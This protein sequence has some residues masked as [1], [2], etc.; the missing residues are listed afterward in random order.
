VTGFPWPEER[1]SVHELPSIYM[2]ALQYP[3]FAITFQHQFFH[4]D[5]GRGLPKNQIVLKNR[6]SWRRL[7]KTKTLP[8]HDADLSVLRALHAADNG[9]DKDDLLAE[10][11]GLPGQ[12]AWGA[13]CSRATAGLERLEA[14]DDE[15]GELGRYLRAVVGPFH[16]FGEDRT[17]G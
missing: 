7:R 16:A 3:A 2:D 12:A 8:K 11:L 4:D 5:N 10:M 9:G 15:W 17:I 13:K 6:D 14:R 1:P